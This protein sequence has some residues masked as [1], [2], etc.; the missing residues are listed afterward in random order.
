MLRYIYIASYLAFFCCPL[1]LQA[2]NTTV[3]RMQ[4]EKK[5]ALEELQSSTILL[6]ETKNTTSSLLNRIQL[7]NSQIET[8][9]ELL[10]ILREEISELEEKKKEIN[11]EI[12]SLNKSLMAKKETYNKTI[13]AMMRNKASNSNSTFLYMLAGK[14]ISESYKRFD[15]LKDYSRWVRE[16]ANIIR[17]DEQNLSQKQDSLNIA[18]KQQ[19][20]ALAQ[21]QFEQAKLTEEEDTFQK[22]L[23]DAQNKEAELT[24]IVSRKKKEAEGLEKKLQAM[25]KAELDKQV[26]IVAKEKN[27]NNKSNN[28]K[29][30][31]ETSTKEI[32]IKETPAKTKEIEN[33]LSKTESNNAALSSSFVANKGKLPFPITGK[34]S[35]VG[36]FGNRKQ[37]NWITTN[38]N[39]IDIQGQKNAKALAIFNGEI[40]SI[41][42]IP[43]YGTCILIRHGNYYSFYGNIKE[44]DVKK[45]QI[46]KTGQQLGTIFVD[47]DSNLSE[48]HFQ[49]WRQKEKLNPEV[50]LRK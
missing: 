2:Q 7:I 46:V 15:Y 33:S 35:I 38:N 30:T 25:L 13:R 21:Y 43:G 9:K 14:S 1:L 37:N 31:A 5:R 45:G 49:L 29:K 47:P 42:N 11:L 34:Y 39:G 3:K 16:E 4:I 12:K 19:N 26:E 28:P 8:R 50:W 27:S 48:L 36:R 44:I 32:V 23:R 10:A 20:I 22:H 18:L 17:A 41:V 6:K 24:K 40:S